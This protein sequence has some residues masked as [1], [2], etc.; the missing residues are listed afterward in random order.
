M[1]LPVFLPCFSQPG[2]TSGEEPMN[3]VDVARPD[4]MSFCG[5]DGRILKYVELS[6]P[7]QLLAGTLATGCSSTGMNTT[8]DC[9]SFTPRAA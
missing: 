3:N 4:N 6:V 1:E 5:A 9:L 8:A 7:T 2:S